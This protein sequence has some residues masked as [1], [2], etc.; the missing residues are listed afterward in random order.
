MDAIENASNLYIWENVSKYDIRF[1]RHM[2]KYPHRKWSDRY[3]KAYEESMT[4]PIAV[5][6]LMN[7]VRKQT[8]YSGQ[9]KPNNN[10]CWRFNKHGKCDLGSSCSMDHKCSFCGKFG[11]YKLICHK[12]KQQSNETDQGK[13]NNEGKSRDRKNLKNA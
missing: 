4:D 13:K 7:L 1:R 8:N 11:H 2:A 9:R 10:A 6:A 3:T 12:F 5:R